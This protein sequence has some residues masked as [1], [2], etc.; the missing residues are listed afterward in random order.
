MTKAECSGLVQGEPDEK[1][2]RPTFET[3]LPAREPQPMSSRKTWSE[4]TRRILPF[5]VFLKNARLRCMLDYSNA[6]QVGCMLMTRTQEAGAGQAGRPAW[7]AHGLD[8]AG[9]KGG[10]Q[11]AQR[12][13]P[14]SSSYPGSYCRVPPVPHSIHTILLC[15]ATAA[16]GTHSL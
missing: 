4:T 16:E 13:A 8:F 14:T 5:L 12:P 11:H 7:G 3:G 15:A 9:M 10:I 2:D 1:A 6:V